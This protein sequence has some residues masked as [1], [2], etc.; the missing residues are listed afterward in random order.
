MHACM[1]T[2]VYAAPCGYRL[3]CRLPALVYEEQSVA[4]Q[5]ALMGDQA[6]C[7]DMPELVR[8]TP[9]CDATRAAVAP[10]CCAAVCCACNV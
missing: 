5:L 6:Q 1:R 8:P 7:D 9:R 3:R 4:R 10:R 2:Y